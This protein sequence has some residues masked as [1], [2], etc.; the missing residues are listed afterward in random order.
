MNQI[1]IVDSDERHLEKIEKMLEVAPESMQFYFVRRP[2]E[3]LSILEKG[4]ID[5]FLCELELPVMSGEELFYMCRLMSPDTIRIALSKAEDIRETLSAINRIGVYKL[6]LKP[7]KFAEDLLVPIESAI[8]VKETL[9]QKL[10]QKEQKQQELEIFDKKYAEILEEIEERNSEYEIM[11]RTVM[12][13]VRNNLKLDARIDSDSGEK[14][15]YLFMEDVY[16]AFIKYYILEPRTWEMDKKL[17]VE[18]FQNKEEGKY[19]HLKNLLET[20]IDGGLVPK[21][22]YS[23]YLM[24]RLIEEQLGKYKITAEICQEEGEIVIVCVC[25]LE[26]SRS[27]SGEMLYLV[28]DKIVFRK[29]YQCVIHILKIISKKVVVGIPNNPY[30]VKVSF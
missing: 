20:E 23:L 26:A 8:H 24:A 21:V 27:E 9:V 25:D 4:E 30:A 14:K 13:I 22:C 6:I 18:E 17:L 28:R 2:E 3:A 29:M 16:K 10:R 19:F 7:C 12:G 5:V 11:F 1:L 15:L